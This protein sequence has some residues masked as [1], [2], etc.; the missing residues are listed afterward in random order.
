MSKFYFFRGSEDQ[1][2]YDAKMIQKPQPKK[3]ADILVAFST[4]PGN[5]KFI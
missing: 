3:H 2:A 1:L 4:L 5:F